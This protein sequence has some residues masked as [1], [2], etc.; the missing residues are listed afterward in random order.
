MFDTT[1]ELLKQIRLG[2]DSSLELK[3]LRYKGDKINEPHSNSIYAAA[4]PDSRVR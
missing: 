3:D 1:D 4:M 2:E